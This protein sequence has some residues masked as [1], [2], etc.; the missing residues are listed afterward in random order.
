MSGKRPLSGEEA[1][2]IY[3]VLGEEPWDDRL[4]PDEGVAAFVRE[5]TA[6]W[7]Q[8]DD[9]P[10]DE[11]DD[12][13][14]AV[15][16]DQSPAHV[17]SAISWSRAEEVFPVYVETA[18]RHGLYSTTGRKRS[19]SRPRSHPRANSRGRGPVPD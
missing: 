15:E 9:V 4:E 13:P 12:C 18:L 7:P 6:R 5:I 14:W 3:E 16:F 11:V 8:I 17:V 2:R 19:F 10:E 1:G